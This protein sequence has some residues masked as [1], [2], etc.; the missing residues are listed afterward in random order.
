MLYDNAYTDY[1]QK[2]YDTG[3]AL[4]FSNSALTDNCRWGRVNDT[5]FQPKQERCRH[6]ADY[7]SRYTLNSHPADCPQHEN[8]AEYRDYWK[9]AYLTRLVGYYDMEGIACLVT[10]TEI[11]NTVLGPTVFFLWSEELPT[12]V[13]SDSISVQSSASDAFVSD[14][15]TLF[16]TVATQEYVDTAI[17]NHVCTH[18]TCCSPEPTPPQNLKETPMSTEKITIEIDAKCIKTPKAVKELTA[19]EKKHTLLVKYY[20]QSGS[21]YS[22]KEFSGKRALKKAKD[23]LRDPAFAGCT[24]VPYTIGKMVRVK[25]DLEEV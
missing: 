21:L 22:S 11:F 7:P 20:S 1:F 12:P 15:T 8:T 19:F 14:G 2:L 13:I 6:S 4:K 17:A 18:S 23:L 10:T 24:M 9:T 25:I 3:V 16:D 5:F